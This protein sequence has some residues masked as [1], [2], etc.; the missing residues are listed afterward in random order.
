MDLCWK[1]QAERMEEEV[2]NKYKVEESKR[3]AFKGRGGSLE[4]RR[5][6]KNKRYNI[7]KW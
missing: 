1:K 5:V 6:R 3:G 2:L 7:R 4:W